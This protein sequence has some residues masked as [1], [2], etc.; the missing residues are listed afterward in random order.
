M[1]D[2]DVGIHEVDG[3]ILNELQQKHPQLAPPTSD[4]LLNGPVNRDLPSCFD[5]IDETMVFKSA[6]MTK[7][8]VDPHDLM[9][10]SIAVFL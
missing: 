7:G 1:T 4:I 8:Q 9:Q 2:T 5:E 6:C 3:T 10:N